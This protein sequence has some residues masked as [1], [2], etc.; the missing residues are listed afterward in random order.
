MNFR[1][2]TQ[3]KRQRVD[4]WLQQQQ[5][6]NG[7]E[8]QQRWRRTAQL[9]GLKQRQ[10]VA[11]DA[12][13]CVTGGAAVHRIGREIRLG[14]PPTGGWNQFQRQERNCLRNPRRRRIEEIEFAERN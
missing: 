11:G 1:N 14:R 13:D 12:A 4:L 5:R 2:N 7:C 6:M 8:R 3:T 10:R 9:L